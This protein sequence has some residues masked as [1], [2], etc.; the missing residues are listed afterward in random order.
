VGDAQRLTPE[1][2]ITLAREQ[3]EAARDFTVAVEEEFAVLDPKTLGLTNRFED[4]QAAA[5]GTPLEGHLVGEL[6]ASEVEIRTGRCEDFE[7]AAAGLGERRAQLFELAESLGVALAATGT[8][9]WSPWQEQ[10]IIDTPHYRR[11]DEIL[12]YVVWRNNTFGFHVHVAINGPDRAIAVCNMLR[13]FLPELLAVSA[14]SPFVENVN[15]GLHSARTQIFTRMFPRCGVPDAY[16]GWDGFERYVRFLYDTRSIDEHTQLWWSVRPHLAFPTVEIRI[17]DAQP[18]LAE[19]RSLAA[20]CY[21]LTARIARALDQ[22]EPMRDFAH[23]MIEEN[24]WRAIRYGLSGELIDL[25]S[26][27]VRPARAQLERLVEW[28]L[29][30]AEE[31]GCASYLAIPPANAA[32]RQIARHEA[33]ASLEEIYAEQVRPKEPVRG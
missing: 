33:G 15:S 14:S 4:L 13:N 24:L 23:R 1:E 11:N 6:I 17:C 16:D 29:P 22:R 19:A 9:P 7:E 27:E 30:V 31:L 3:Y 10:R 5:Q 20:L 8:H 2:Q 28:V 12:R 21:A 32:E 25:A 26:A 18:D